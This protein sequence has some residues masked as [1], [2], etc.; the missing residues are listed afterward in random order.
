MGVFM[1][2][3]TDCYQRGTCYSKSL[4]SVDNFVGREEDI[5][6]ITGYLDF[7]TSDV[8]VVHIVGPPGFGKSTLAKKVGEILVRKRVNVHYVDVRQRIIKDVD[9]LSENIVL[10]MVESRRDRV[11]LSDLEGKVRKTN[12]ETLIILDN[13]DELFEY[14]KKEFFEALKVLTLASHQKSVRFLITSQNQE[15]DIG[16]FR[17]HAIYNLSSEEAL[18]LLHRVAPGLTN[19][20]MKEI[21]H[22]TGNVPLA[23]HIIGATFK[24]PDAKSAER[25]IRGLRDHPLQVLNPRNVHTKINI[26]ID[27]A[28]KYLKPELKLLCYNLSHFP[29]SFDRDT[30]LFFFKFSTDMLDELVQRSLVQS[31]HGRQRYYFHQL[32]RKFFLSKEGGTLLHFDAQ[33]Q[34][35]FTGILETIISEVKLTTLDE[36]KHNIIHMFTLF[37]RA[38]FT[39]VTLTG[40]NMTLRAIEMN[41]LQK[42][43]LPVEIYG[44]TQDMLSALDTYTPH[45]QAMVTSFLETYFKVVK[46]VAQHQ[47]SVHKADAIK[48][49]K[50][51]TTQIDVGYMQNLIRVNTFTDYF[52]LLAQ[53]YKWTGED[54]KAASCDTHILNII[55]GQLKHCSPDCDYL[56]ISIA[57]ENIGDRMQAFAFRELAYQHQLQSVKPM[58]KAKLI[59][60]LYNDYSNETVGND[61]AKARTLSVMVID[62]IYPYLNTADRSQYSERTFYDAI[63]FFTA[64]NMEEH[65]V[66]L[67]QKMIDNEG[68]CNCTGPLKDG[69][70][71]NFIALNIKRYLRNIQLDPDESKKHCE[72]KC[73]AHYADIAREAFA[74][75]CHHLAIWAGEQSCANLDKLGD[76][77]M[78]FKL[79]PASLIGISYFV[80]G[81]NISATLTW[82]KLAVRHISD[83]ISHEYF[84]YELRALRLRVCE[85]IL[86]VSWMGLECY[87]YNLQD[88]MC[89]IFTLPVMAIILPIYLWYVYFVGH[90][91]MILSAET[92][93]IDLKQDNIWSQLSTVYNPNF[94]AQWTN[95]AIIVGAAIGTIM[96]YLCVSYFCRCCIVRCN[97]C[98]NC[99]CIRTWSRAIITIVVV[100]IIFCVY[101][102]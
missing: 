37:K 48:T 81:N 15:S 91:E 96:Y 31:S 7:T 92:G 63:D 26:S 89:L 25:V 53:Y 69:E 28:Y 12:R 64:L 88:G 8:Q 90:E 19:Y 93:L 43:F 85:H 47:W 41:V 17:L 2:Y 35:Y 66:L 78:V 18:E 60:D 82:L 52:N 76:S 20:Q 97:C 13:C 58:E 9:T 6:N 51:R 100:L 56:S 71:F 84:C 44:I 77:Y 16:N 1:Y 70:F 49:L 94:V 102:F 86:K 87:F 75:K 22:L 79:G 30:A 23:L 39:N 83:A 59:L 27:L 50:S 42:R 74:K 33:F 38:K 5:R 55:H 21:A 68:M 14:A 95:T 65:V 61:Q 40:I 24:S 98:C 67:Q 99:F 72:Y 36:E 3:N 10:T 11:T 29:G 46:L 34:L 45:E 32:L 57:Y 54:R 62:E 73:A 80:L 4:P 101:W